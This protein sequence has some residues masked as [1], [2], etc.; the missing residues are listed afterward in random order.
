[1][2]FHRFFASL[3]G[4][5]LSI[6][7]L[8]ACTP[9]DPTDNSKPEELPC[10]WKADRNLTD[11]NAAVDY[12]INCKLEVT[13]KLTIQ[14]GVTI[15]F[16]K[17][18]GLLFVEKGI[19]VAKGTKEKPIVFTGSTNT[20]GSWLGI[21][22][23]TDQDNHLS[24]VT[25]T[26]GGSKAFDS[27]DARGNVIVSNNGRL[28]LENS[29]L[30][31]S[32][33]YGLNVPDDSAKITLKSNTYTNNKNPIA[34]HGNHLSMLDS[35]SN[36]KGNTEDFVRV[37]AGEIPKSTTWNK[38]NVPYRVVQPNVQTPHITIG[39]GV[40]LTIQAGVSLQFSK[41]TGISVEDGSIKA[42]GSDKEPIRFLGS[43]NK[44][45]HWKGI[46][47][48]GGQSN[49]FKYVEIAH[50]GGG[51]FDSDGDLGVMVVFA[52][53]G[54][55]TLTNSTFREGASDCAINV[56]YGGLTLDLK[57]NTHKGFKTDVC[58]KK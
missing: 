35:A 19:L 11:R 39:K 31:N 9:V 49:L 58:Q 40:T 51:A 47:I 24:Y 38:I 48:N 52:E 50:A 41:G 8:V 21:Q 57:D 6:T 26:S 36:Y 34:L 3:F 12:V 10:E 55:L 7:L 1:M 44:A 33:D 4:L 45:G 32:A 25:V 56:V 46:A 30:S 17:D 37:S 23:E 27:N 22:L 20:K 5:L 43:E 42:E 15:A 18:A 28:T 16:G 14:P 13:G 53:K 54:T 2:N 29:T